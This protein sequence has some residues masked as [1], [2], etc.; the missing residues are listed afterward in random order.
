[1]KVADFG[2]D[3]RSKFSAHIRRIDILKFKGDKC[4]YKFIYPEGTCNSP[5]AAANLAEEA[6][7]MPEI[8]GPYH[9][10]KNNCEHFA[11][12]CKTGKPVSIQ[13]EHAKKILKKPKEAAARSA[14]SAC[15][16]L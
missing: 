14:R 11:T 3:S 1:M 15:Y 12:K 6:V 8:W 16:L 9:F 5:E 10:L 7:G 4:L 2:T 13:V